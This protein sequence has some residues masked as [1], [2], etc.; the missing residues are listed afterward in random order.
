M[1][2]RRFSALLASS[3]IIYFRFSLL[4]SISVVLKHFRCCF[5]PY[6]FNAA[7]LELTGRLP[8]QRTRRMCC[9]SFPT[10]CVLRLMQLGSAVLQCVCLACALM[11]TRRHNKTRALSPTKHSC[12]SFALP[13]TPLSQVNCSTPCLRQ[14]SEDAGSVSFTRAYVQ[15]ALCAPTR[16]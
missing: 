5:P 15:Q 9:W 1:R 14:L 4:H 12:V 13:H 6:C 3:W 16:T 8:D 2:E 11:G 10:T 7:L